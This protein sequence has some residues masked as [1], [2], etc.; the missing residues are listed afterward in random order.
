MVEIAIREIR[1]PQDRL[2][3]EHLDTSF[4]SDVIYEV[5]ASGDGFHLTPARA[6]PT[7]QKSFPIDDLDNRQWDSA[8]VVD[9]GQIR[10][11]IATA[12]ETWNRRLVIWHFYVAPTHRRKGFGRRLLERALEH[13]REQGARLAWLETTN[14]NYPGVQAY[15]RLGFELCGLDS[16]LYRGTGAEGEI[17]LF[18]ARPLN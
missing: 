10:G 16:T 9:D 14:L 17:A 13:G 5:T 7:V 8:Y 3:L 18:L 6:S 2:A 15:R 12:F 1:L 11:F 4:T